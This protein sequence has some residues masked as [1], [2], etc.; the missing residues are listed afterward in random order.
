MGRH[1]PQSEE[2]D[3][4]PVLLRFRHGSGVVLVATTW[5]AENRLQR[6]SAKVFLFL[7]LVEEEVGGRREGSPIEIKS[8]FSDDVCEMSA[9]T[10]PLF[11]LLLLSTRFPT[12]QVRK[13][14]G[15]SLSSTRGGGS[16]LHGDAAIS[17]ASTIER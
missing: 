8:R 14:R 15:D 3:G 4:A 5:N 2:E 16:A 6:I 1:P 12:R 10:A 7:S 13:E 9:T 17:T 11:S